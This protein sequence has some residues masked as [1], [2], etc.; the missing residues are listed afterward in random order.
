M[1]SCHLL[2]QRN[3]GY[4][5]ALGTFSEWRKLP[6]YCTFPRFE[7]ASSRFDREDMSSLMY[8]PMIVEFLAWTTIDVKPMYGDFGTINSGKIKMARDV[9]VFYLPSHA[10]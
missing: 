2:P 9:R 3:K 1:E 7:L 6:F 10:Q 5:G 4:S 8:F